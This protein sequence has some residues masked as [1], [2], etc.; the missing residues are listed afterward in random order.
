MVAHNDDFRK[1]YDLGYE[2]LVPIVPPD[3]PLSPRSSLAKRSAAGKDARG[4]AVG[5]RGEDGLW[6]GFD[7]FRAPPADLDAVERW[8][9]MGAGCGIR[10]GYGIVALDIDALS[11]SIS[12]TAKALALEIL[13]PA[14]LRY[15]R[16]PKCLLVYAAPADT[17]YQRIDF[18]DTDGAT[19]K[20]G[21]VELLAEGRQFVASG[22]HP[23]TLTPYVWE[24]PL[25]GFD[26]LPRVT[27]QALATYFERLSQLLPNAT[28]PVTHTTSPR[29]E[30]QATLK[31]DVA[32]VAQAVAALPNSSDLFPTYDDYIR[33]G[34]A[35]KGA[36][37]DDPDAGLDLFLQW[38]GRW[39]GDNDPER[40]AADY[41]RIRPPF[42][43]GA[44]YLYQLS[45]RHG[46]FNLGSV[47]F[48]DLSDEDAPDTHRTALEVERAVEASQ[49]AVRSPG[50]FTP[51]LDAASLAVKGQAKPLVKGLLDQGT[52]SVLY[53]RSN[54]GKTFVAI[55]IAFHVA[56]GLPWAGMRTTK[57]PVVYIA[58]EGGSG[59]RKRA[60]ALIARFGEETAKQADFAFV[61]A[62]VDLFSKDGDTAGLIKAVNGL[63]PDRKVGLI[64]IDTLARAMA[65]GDENSAQDMGV[66]IRNIDKI[67]ADTSAHVMVIHH[68]GKDA[69]KGARGSNALL[70]AVDTELEIADSVVRVTKQRDLDKSFSTGFVLEEH[71]LGEDGDGE[72]VTSCTV[73][74]VAVKDVAVGEPTITEQSV[75]DAIGTLAALSEGGSKDGV[76]VSEIASYIGDKMSVN[77]LKLHMGRLRKK[78]QIVRVGH[79]KWALSA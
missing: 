74:L 52:F 42:S 6:H 70:G 12:D 65:G 69:A 46:D 3:A 20:P 15:G 47:L 57:L 40:A 45:A 1:Y 67:R 25:C 24:T 51:L 72:F 14:P 39:D 10:T 5:V 33:V 44:D 23:A 37:Q 49:A 66:L 58:A 7:W 38:A 13:G 53:G 79:A 34:A 30:D 54:S 21:R 8:A 4:K 73:K 19:K 76:G 35:I 55:D 78:G 41:G 43:I 11:P 16:R 36:T 31:G 56:A 27:A 18:D 77:A 22:I 59:A 60:A 61:L 2:Y 26:Y 63:Y 64:V 62:T 75:L 17:P 68:S 28:K 48:D 71:I 29:A 50:P 32:A 9:S